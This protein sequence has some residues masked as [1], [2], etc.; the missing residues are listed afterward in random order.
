MVTTVRFDSERAKTLEKMTT[1][2]HKKKSEV[3]RE[4]LDFYAEHILQSR[5][6]RIAKAA[7]KVAKADAQEMKI[8]DTIVDD[9]L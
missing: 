7:Q 5:E 1:L 9:G 6:S 3:I 2:L 8:W 4:A